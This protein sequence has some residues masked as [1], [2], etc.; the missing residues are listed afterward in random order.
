MERKGLGQQD[1]PGRDSHGRVRLLGATWRA[2]GTGGHGSSAAQHLWVLVSIGDSFCLYLHLSI[3]LCLTLFSFCVH[4][5]LCSS[6]SSVYIHFSFFLSPSPPLPLESKALPHSPK[7]SS[8]TE[9]GTSKD[10]SLCIP[11]ISHVLCVLS[12]SGII[13]VLPACPWAITMTQS[14]WGMMTKF[15]SFACHPLL[16]PPHS[17]LWGGGLIPGGTCG[18]PAV[19][20]SKYSLAHEPTLVYP[21]QG[22]DAAGSQKQGSIGCTGGT[23]QGQ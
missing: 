9:P 10:P 2:R 11:L 21:S 4:L 18:P 12:P 22:L 1:E 5:F 14:W 16:P 8:I 13:L 3:S 19:P 20:L 17:D 23:G 7:A 6:V 15:I